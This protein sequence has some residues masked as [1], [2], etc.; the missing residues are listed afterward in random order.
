MF[1][2]DSG[3]SGVTTRLGRSS[4]CCD[5][6]HQIFSSAVEWLTHTDIA[7][8]CTESNKL[9]VQSKVRTGIVACG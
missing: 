9:H 5:L 8:D 2:G 3:D 6:D 7:W 1:S 4:N